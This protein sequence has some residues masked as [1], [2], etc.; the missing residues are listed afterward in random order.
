MDSLV[1]TGN[2]KEHQKKTSSIPKQVWNV[3]SAV[4]GDEKLHK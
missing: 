2:N 1:S 3:Y 4:Y